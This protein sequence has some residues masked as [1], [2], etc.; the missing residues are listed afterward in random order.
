MKAL[1]I[2]TDKI[3]R[4]VNHELSK[5]RL[6]EFDNILVLINLECRFNVDV[7]REWV[8]GNLVITAKV[9]QSDALNEYCKVQLD[10]MDNRDTALKR[11]NRIVYGHNY[12]E[13]KKS[14]KIV[15]VTMTRGS[16]TLRSTSRL[17]TMLYIIN[18]NTN[19]N[20]TTK[21]I[22]RRWMLMLQISANSRE[23]ELTILP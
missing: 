10:W 20:L 22:H 21:M 14:D 13:H 4:L 5:N 12:L 11:I 17:D 16:D 7:N 6:T 1:R 2:T 3:T 8:D 19:L 18:E 23:F 15:R 9:A